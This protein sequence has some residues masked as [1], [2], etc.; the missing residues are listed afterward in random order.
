MF[1]MVHNTATMRADV[2]RPAFPLADPKGYPDNIMAAC[3]AASCFNQKTELTVAKNKADLERKRMSNRLNARRWRKRKRI[4]LSFLDEK[5][6]ALQ[7]EH[8]ALKVENTRLQVELQE[9]TALA[10]IEVMYSSAAFVDARLSRPHPLLG[11]TTA[12]IARPPPGLSQKISHLTYSGSTN[13]PRVACM[14]T[15]LPVVRP[16]LPSPPT[17]SLPL[18]IDCLRLVQGQSPIFILRQENDTFQRLHK[19]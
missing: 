10:R 9:E 8:E 2:D 7:K 11:G 15:R 19:T 13:C 18:P 1:E 6:K 17:L 4:K 5:I 14:Y 16:I 3:Q 12:S